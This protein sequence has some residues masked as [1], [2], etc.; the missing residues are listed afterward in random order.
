MAKKRKAT[1]VLT[2]DSRKLNKELAKAEKRF[3]G[4]GK[5][6]KGTGKGIGKTLGGMAS[7]FGATGGFGALGAG[8][9][10]GGAIKDAVAFDA[11]LTDL[12]IATDGAIGPTELLRDNIL[13][14]SKQHGEAKEKILAG[15]AAY[16]RLTGD[17]D[18]A[19]DSMDAFT[20]ISIA[21]GSNMEDIASTA[22]AL[23][24][25][26]GIAPKEFE[27]A[28]SV[29]AATGKDGSV[30][31]SDMAT[32]LARLTPQIEK[33]AG[34]RGMAGMGELSAALQLINQGF[35]DSAMSATAFQSLVGALT[36]NASKF[37]KAGVKI[38]EVGKDG[39]K[40]F[41][42]F[43]TIIDEIGAS[44]L[45]KDPTLLLDAF[46]RKEAQDAFVQLVKNKGAW[47]GLVREADRA[48][49]IS[50]DYATR[51]SSNS[52]KVKKA[53]NSV[54]VAFA[55][56]MTPERVAMIANAL[57]SV[58]DV[59]ATIVGTLGEIPDTI[60]AGAHATNDWLS[61]ML[62][63]KDWKWKGNVDTSTAKG[64][65][66][67]R[68]QLVAQMFRGGGLQDIAGAGRHARIG[69]AALQSGNA[70]AA[71]LETGM[72]P[73]RLGVHG[74][75]PTGPTYGPPDPGEWNKMARDVGREMGKEMKKALRSGPG[76]SNPELV[77]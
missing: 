43:R 63:A 32:I 28:F 34:G 15:A 72:Q 38:F 22:A 4:F 18:A 71:E 17:A 42:N 59:A 40:S 21:T 33:F 73:Q 10:V 31:L 35:N 44:D 23:G 65:A 3:G 77:Q 12:A 52:H 36:K 57:T 25:N 47:E 54:R 48:D 13:S 58:A 24:Q 29:L 41:R 9:V 19:R 37:E 61:D 75:G 62:G 14:L 46:G 39:T 70:N 1:A 68:A 56:A 55:E 26:L 53:W 5:R 16:V 45:A 51:T 49:T 64:Q 76:G 6:V 67:G 60:R 11:A 8:L 20:R 27:H 74:P 69:M 66:Q 7:R 2:A 50:K 30:E